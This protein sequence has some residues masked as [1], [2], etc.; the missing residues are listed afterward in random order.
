LV[1]EVVEF[2]ALERGNS[3]LAG[4]AGFIGER[5][6]YYLLKAEPFR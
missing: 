2:F 6:H 3:A 5:R 1:M 4:N